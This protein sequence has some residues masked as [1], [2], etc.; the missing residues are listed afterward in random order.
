MMII[1]PKENPGKTYIDNRP[2]AIG[3]GGFG[4]G[5]LICVLLG[6]FLLDASKLM[7]DFKM[8]AKN[9]SHFT[10]SVKKRLFAK[11]LKTVECEII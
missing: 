6:V 8:L 1:F 4:A 10:K 2:S 7:K 3:I 11:R 5:V 9:I